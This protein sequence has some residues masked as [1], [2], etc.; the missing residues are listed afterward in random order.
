MSAEPT[1]SAT[2][3]TTESVEAAPSSPV[4]SSVARAVTGG[5]VVGDV[6]SQAPGRSDMPAQAGGQTGFS[7][8][9]GA[10]ILTGRPSARAV[11]T[12]T[13]PG[14]DGR[15]DDAV[16][17]AATRIE[18]FVQHHRATAHR[19]PRRPRSTSPTTAATSTSACTRTTPTWG[20]FARIGPIET[21]RSATIRS[22]STS[23]RSWISS[24]PT[25]SR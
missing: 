4:P 7:T 11:R 14:I 9:S 21:R 25:S 13:P 18:A 20:S 24:G 3:R 17:Q 12:S 8:A 5:L 6:A 23:T 22:R 10:G 19:Q 1:P 2:P 15:L 16:W